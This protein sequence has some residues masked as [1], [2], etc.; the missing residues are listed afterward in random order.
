LV[1][2]KDCGKSW[3][4]RPDSIPKWLGRCR[5]CN[6]K[7]RCEDPIYKSRVSERARVQVLRQGGI[8]NAFKFTKRNGSN[9]AYLE[10]N[11]RWKGG[12]N[13]KHG[14]AMYHE[15]RIKVYSRDAFMCQICNSVGKNLNAHHIKP[16][17]KYPALRYEISNGITLCYTCHR[18]VHSTKNKKYLEV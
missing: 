12:I 16:F 4:K 6:T 2:C 8:P 14:G 3:N 18:M 10:N 7:K 17:Y 5:S 1:S 11:K 13:I 15:W 9:P